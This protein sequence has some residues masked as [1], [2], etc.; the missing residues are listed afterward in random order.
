M[1]SAAAADHTGGVFSC[2]RK[3]SDMARELLR[4]FY[5]SLYGVAVAGL[6]VVLYLCDFSAGVIFV[7]SSAFTIVGGTLLVRHLL[8][9][10]I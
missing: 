4:T 2:A 1:K 8:A 5:P 10:Q 6:V 7:A 3:M 9:D